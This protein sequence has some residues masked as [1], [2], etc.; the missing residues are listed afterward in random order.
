LGSGVDHPFSF[1]VKVKGRVDLYI[2]F[3]FGLTWPVLKQ[4]LSLPYRIWIKSFPVLLTFSHALG[5]HCTCKGSGGVCQTAINT[6]RITLT[7]V[8]CCVTHFVSAFVFYM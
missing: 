8:N 7:T 4:T 2:Y 3:A 1:S 6:P 5:L